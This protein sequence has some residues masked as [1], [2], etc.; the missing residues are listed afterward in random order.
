M[1]VRIVGTKNLTW[2]QKL[3]IFAGFIVL[4]VVALF[5]FAVFAAFFVVSFVVGS[6]WL[7]WRRWRLRRMRNTY[8]DGT[9]R[10]EYR[11]IRQRPERLP[12]QRDAD[13]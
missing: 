4:L 8:D 7:A 5:F 11:E 2:W 9:I 12:K 6:V 13:E 3:G 10:A 1:R